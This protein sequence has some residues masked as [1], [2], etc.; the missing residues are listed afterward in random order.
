MSQ[1]VLD[2][3]IARRSIRRYQEKQITPQQLDAILT[4]ACYA[5]S[6]SN[7]Q[8][9]Q[10]TVLQ[11]PA[12]L[13]ELAEVVRQALLALPEEPNEYPAK[14]GSR[15]AAQ[16]PDYNFYYR[17]PTLIIAS[18]VASYGNAMA[19]CSAALQ[20]MFLTAH[21]LGLGTCWINQM[22]WLGESADFRAYLD[23]IGVPK[24]HRICGAVAVGYSDMPQPQ[25]PPRKEGTVRIIT[26]DGI[27]T[28]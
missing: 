13:A 5:P 4:A 25:A 12:V 9:W 14:A 7:S 19:D 17:S 27:T 28:K 15:K 2:A 16:N 11:D 23:K 10:F 26:S 18:N 1:P 22:T 6:G 21:E 20:N 3:I 8:S 24:D